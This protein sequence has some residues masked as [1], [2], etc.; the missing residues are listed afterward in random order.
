LV[1][2]LLGTAAL[3]ALLTPASAL[4]GSYNWGDSI[5]ASGGTLTIANPSP[6]VSLASLGS[7]P[8]T[9]SRPTL[10]GTAGTRVIDSEQVT[11]LIYP[12]S[13]TSSPPIRQLTGSVNSDGHFAVEVTPAL[14]DGEYTALARQDS[15]AG[16]GY[17]HPLTFR[18]KAHAP[19]LTLE[20]PAGGV[21]LNV[22]TPTFS[23]QAGDALGDSRTVKL[24]L[25][26]GKGTS[27]RSAGTERVSAAGSTWSLQWPHRLAYGLYTAVAVQTDDAGHTSRTAPHTFTVAPTPH[28]IG[29]SAKL[30]PSG[31]ASVSVGC[32]AGP[33]ATCTGTVLM[34]TQRSYRT[35]AGGP[36]GP[37]EVLFAKVRISGGR[38]EVIQRT[39][40][41]PV[42]SLLRRHRQVPVIVTVNLSGPSSG[43]MKASAARVLLVQR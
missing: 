25:F 30:S 2:S 38:S 18:I 21:T 26:H 34:V 12:G 3:V 36:R 5:G 10:K 24:D 22:V 28:L 1:A 16:T 33:G 41:G 15:V 42:L 29:A 39:V 13:D 40:S 9:D 20:H 4:A 6:T 27:G 35:T 37:L 11:V 19:A 7:A 8:L 17:S 14:A 32:L 23:G 31:A 43:P